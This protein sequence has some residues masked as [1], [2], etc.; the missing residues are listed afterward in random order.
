MFNFVGRGPR[1]GRRKFWRAEQR[2][3]KEGKGGKQTPQPSDRHRRR[4]RRRRRNGSWECNRKTGEKKGKKKL[5]GGG[6]SIWIFWWRPQANICETAIRLTRAAAFSSVAPKRETE[7]GENRASFS[8]PAKGFALSLTRI[9]QT[10]ALPPDVLC[11]SIHSKLFGMSRSLFKAIFLRRA[12]APTPK[13]SFYRSLGE[14]PAIRKKCQ[15]TFGVRQCLSPPLLLP[16]PP[17]SAFHINF[18]DLT[19]GRGGTP[20]SLPI[21][22][23]NWV[24]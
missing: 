16:L 11:S 22:T 1:G 8:T 12:G 13:P 14:M 21:A 19:Q 4:W 23:A 10:S 18:V 7:E 3:R 15:N 5:P 17:S 24:P 6:N 2:K 9:L 20:L